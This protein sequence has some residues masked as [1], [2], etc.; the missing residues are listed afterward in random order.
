MTST[1]RTSASGDAAALPP[2]V[3]VVVA[4]DPGDWF[5]QTLA[6]ID[7]Q[8]YANLSVLVID[9]GSHQPLAARIAAVLPDAHERRLEANP[10]FGPACN[11]VLG[12]VQGA[13][14]YLL[15]HDDVRLEPDA[16]RLLVEE[17]FRSNAGIV[18][19]KLVRWDDPDRL[20]AVGMGADKLGQPAPLV[21]PGELDQSQHDPVR[22][23]FYV[24]GA[25]TLVRAD[26]FA[27]LSG[28]DPGIDLHGEDLDLCWRA[29]VAGANVIVAPAARVA[30]LEALAHRR[31]ADDRRRL[32][33][34]HRLRVVLCAYGPA[35]RLRVLPQGLVLT[36]VEV[37]YATLLGRFGQARD[38]AG[39]W[40]WNLRRLGEVRA[41]RRAVATVRS[42]SD[43]DVR[44]LQVGGSARVA[45]FLRGRLGPDDERITSTLR[46][47]TAGSSLLAWGAVLFV[48]LVGS[49]DLLTDKLP[50]IGDFAAFPASPG[51]LL[52]E[53]VRGYND[54][55]VGVEG[56]GPPALGLFGVSSVLAFGSTSLARTLLVLAALPIGAAGAWRLA[57]PIGSRRA[58]IA[59]LLVFVANPLMY[60]ALA[61]GRWS[62]MVMIA[63]GPWM[64]LHLARASGVVPYGS[65]GG[66]AGPGAPERPLVHHILH[67]GLVVAVA[68]L[69][70]P[71][72]PLIVGVMAAAVVVGGL[73]VGQVAGAVRT[74]VAAV[75]AAVV[76]G[77][78][79]APWSLSLA[80]AP[81]DVLLGSSLGDAPDLAVGELLRFQTGPVG[82]STFGWALL[83]GSSLALLIGRSWRLAWAA[84][85]WMV[86][87]ASWG[88]VILV[89]QGWLP[90]S[91]SVP[92]P[93]VLLAPAVGGLALAAAMGM[94]AFETDLPDYHFGWR[95]LASVVA[96]A[97]VV[98][99]ILPVLASAASGRWDMPQRDVGETLALSPEVEAAGAY[100]VLWVGDPDVVPL[101]GWALPPTG[102]ERPGQRFVL[103][104]SSGGAPTVED[105][106]LGDAPS[107]T[108]LLLDALVVAADG[109]TTRLGSL[110]APMGV[111]YI[112]VPDRLGPG[113][114][115]VPQGSAGA[116]VDLLS[117]QLDLSPVQ[118]GAGLR[119]FRNAAWVPARASVGAEVVLPEGGDGVAPVP[120][121]AG[122]TP[123]LPGDALTPVSGPVTGPAQVYV[124]DQASS[125][126]ALAVDGRPAGRDD[127]LGWAMAFPIDQ[128]GEA[129]LA[130]DSPIGRRAVAVAPVVLWLAVALYLLRNRV[131][132]DERRV[133]DV[134]AGAEGPA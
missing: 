51:E 1:D 133:I 79:L 16:V 82:A 22:E 43:H 129:T 111:R 109:G 69:W 49:R 122:A 17:A 18:G 75:G 7:A 63:L 76:A 32:Q 45:G 71:V 46:S 110:L 28:F 31:P 67:L 131:A 34:R 25:A 29:H 130:Y 13:A 59:G 84:R 103:G 86:A 23:V 89:E 30:H 9:A 26:L 116:L 97:G 90:E 66:E 105:L 128:G 42:V 113:E 6:S 33:M 14:F 77:A 5:E 72:A 100:R 91:L 38:V 3:V 127:V 78:L 39:A 94:A 44:A 73:L 47:S 101:A 87:L 65:T 54:I 126:W 62:G 19:P 80:G 120:E 102:L 70:L 36:V 40:W 124:A 61:Q 85:G 83:L 15:C 37:V 57:R 117:R 119:M 35:H 81:A 58:R 20:L 4:H 96:A 10:G 11:E 115:G 68:G 118:T 52:A 125:A 106:W 95:Q 98:V 41:R 56:P 24:P 107:G 114:E 104:T 55:G 134:A 48:L 27:A 92:V 21:E 2:V 12:A 93:E 74:L 50:A 108:Q 132:R 121:L 112:I 123:V 88:A 64:L 60:N 53:W 99:S 8:T